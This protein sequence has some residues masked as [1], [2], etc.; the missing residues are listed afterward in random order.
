MKIDDLNTYHSEDFDLV[1][2]LEG[3]FQ[4]Q[5]ST[6]LVIIG[7]IIAAIKLFEFFYFLYNQKQR[8]MKKKYATLSQIIKFKS[9]AVPNRGKVTEYISC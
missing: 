8:S 3:V 4:G 7:S 5:V 2:N 1:E 9:F 6:K